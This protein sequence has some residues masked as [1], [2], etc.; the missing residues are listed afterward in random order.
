[1]AVTD[2]SHLESTDTGT[3]RTSTDLADRLRL[4]VT[5][6]ARQLRRHSEIGGASPTQLSALASID[7]HGP[8]TLG[9]LAA[10]EGVQPPTIT[11][12]VGRLEQQGLVERQADPD[13]GRI[14]RVV[15]TR[16]GRRLLS[17]NRSRKTAFLVQRLQELDDDDRARLAAA[18]DV[19]ER[20]LEP[21]PDSRRAP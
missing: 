3:P 9:E 8:L 12:A 20:V 18:V 7:R 4:A 2:R 10:H 15:V 1:M 21:E 17:R 13:D 16:D 14:V 5:R 11:A 6:L 19:L